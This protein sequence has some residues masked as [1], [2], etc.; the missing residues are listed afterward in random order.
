MELEELIY[1]LLD[2]VRNLL[3][4]AG[5][6]A[7]I[8]WCIDHLISPL[9][10]AFKSI[11]PYLKCNKPQSLDKQFGQWAIVTGSTDGIGKQLAMELAKK[12]LNICLIART[13]SKLIDTANEI[14]E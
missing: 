11:T 5:V 13:Q 2:L 4:L 7:L 10:F 9:E 12:G 6:Y 8:W 3:A 14:G 1:L